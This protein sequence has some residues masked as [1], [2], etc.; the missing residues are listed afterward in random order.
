MYLNGK[1]MGG[2]AVAESMLYTPLVGPLL[3]GAFT[4]GVLKV[5]YRVARMA[6]LGL[7]IL[8]ATLPFFLL[9]PRENQLFFVVPMCKA[10]LFAAIVYVIAKI[11]HVRQPA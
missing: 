10:L 5:L 3:A 2:S 4:G 7:F 9:I 6:P 8:A 11:H 1:G